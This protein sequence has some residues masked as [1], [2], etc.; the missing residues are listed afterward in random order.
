MPTTQGPGQSSVE[1]CTQHD[2][3]AIKYFCKKHSIFG[4]SPCVTIN[5]RTCDII[6]ISD[7]AKDFKSSEELKNLLQRIEGIKSSCIEVEENI[8]KVQQSRETIKNEI[9][10]FRKQINDQIDKWEIDLYS[11]NDSF[12]EEKLKEVT[13]LAQ[14]RRELLR[15]AN[16]AQDNLTWLTSTENNVTLYIEAKKVEKNLQPLEQ[17]AEELKN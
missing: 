16:K 10:I 2:G 12:H 13:S 6:Y 15:Y 14:K 17:R 1:T 4:C 8:A 7:A 3:E 11:K 5:H 9:K